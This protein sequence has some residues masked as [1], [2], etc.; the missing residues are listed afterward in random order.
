MVHGGLKR[1]TGIGSEDW[2]DKGLKNLRGTNGGEVREQTFGLYL[3]GKVS[4]G[5]T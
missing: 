5:T 1:G 2:D 4:R 3:E